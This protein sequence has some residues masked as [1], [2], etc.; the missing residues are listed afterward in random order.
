MVFTT[1]QIT[2]ITVC[3]TAGVA[4]ITAIITSLVALK[5]NALSRKNEHKLA[6]LKVLLE[7]AY[8]EYE[9]KTKADIEDAN[10]KNIVPKIKSFSEYVIFYRE[11]AEVFSHDIVNKEDIVNSLEKNKV[12][13]DTYYENR[14]KYR[15]EF[16]KTSNFIKN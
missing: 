16:H 14:E 6:V 5:T 10:Q 13:I 3:I 2:L 7:V 8:K 9:F 15:P 12:L 11:I 4:F 1:N